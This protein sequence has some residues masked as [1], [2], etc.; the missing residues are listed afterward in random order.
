MTMLRT[1]AAWLS[2]LVAT[3]LAPG[4][5]L[6]MFFPLRSGTDLRARVEE[7][8]RETRDAVTLVLRP[9]RGWAGHRAG[10]YVRVTV[11]V[12]GVRHQ[13]AYS[14][15]G[16]PRADGCLTITVKAIPD[17]K[18]STHLVRHAEAGMLI[19]LAQ[20]EGEF[21]L[22]E[23]L[24]G[25]SLF[26]TAG[27]GITPVMG[28]LRESL[29]ALRDVVVV[30]SAPAGRDVIFGAELRRLARAG[31][32]RLVEWHSDVDG[33]LGPDRLR[34][35]VPDWAERETWACGPVGLL[36]DLTTMWA[37]AERADRLHVERFRP[38]VVV[39][40]TGGTATFVRSGVAVDADAATPLLTVGEDADVL[41]P[42]G[43]RMGICFGCVVPLRDGAVRDL[44]TGE[45]TTASD[46]APV[47]IQT[48]VSAAAG[49]CRIDL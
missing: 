10:Q 22:P 19:G 15:T 23:A 8:R 3:P 7:V 41:M 16:P 35:L 20:A 48:C 43:C 37:A 5:Y 11:D 2:G 34:R 49:P 6:D 46:G 47:P 39:T 25:K 45:V 40:G 28:L 13:R 17:G 26:V 32:I 14:L 9:G 27:S 31:E 36:D 24:P 12:D 33:L 18:V 38:A 30:H 29:P 1:G 4:D 42:S 21:V 44:R